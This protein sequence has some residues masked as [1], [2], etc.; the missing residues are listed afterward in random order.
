MRARFG[1]G[2]EINLG[3]DD[4]EK[5][6]EGRILKCRLTPWKKAEVRLHIIDKV[7]LGFLEELG[8]HI[9]VYPK[10]SSPETRKRYDIFLS[11][12]RFHKLTNPEGNPVIDGGH[13][14]SRCLYDRVDI[15]YF[16]V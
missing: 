6:D 16:A 7:P 10:N 15:N 9:E 1:G 5:G 3:L 2:L 8:F 4:K 13:F 12:E 11:K 14:S